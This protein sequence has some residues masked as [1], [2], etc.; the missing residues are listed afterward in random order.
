MGYIQI[1]GV[2]QTLRALSKIEPTVAKEVNRKLYVA[3]KSIAAIANA[4]IPGDPPLSGWRTVAPTVWSAAK[5]TRG[6]AGWPAW[7]R[8]SFSGRKG[9][10]MSTFVEMKG[11]LATGMIAETANI[12]GVNSERGMRLGN[13]LPGIVRPAKGKP[14]RLLRAANAQ[15]YPQTVED[16]REATR[17][18]EETV[19]RM[20][21]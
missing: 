17:L 19:E 5:L 16:I 4:R 9:K 6:G 8:F 10:G 1:T 18:A 13:S 2:D 21:P 7:Q 15:R 12:N 11:A 20:L 3:G 14:G